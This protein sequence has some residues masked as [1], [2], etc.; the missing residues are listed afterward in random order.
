MGAS[1]TVASKLGEG[2]S[3]T[4][5]LPI[6]QVAPSPPPCE[7]M[8]LIATDVETK[9][10]YDEKYSPVLVIDPLYEA[11][12]GIASLLRGLGRRAITAA[13]LEEAEEIFKKGAEEQKSILMLDVT[14]KS[15][16]SAV[17]IHMLSYVG[18]TQ[19]NR[20]RCIEGIRKLFG[21][22]IQ[23]IVINTHRSPIFKI[24]EHCSLFNMFQMKEPVTSKELK[25]Q[26]KQASGPDNTTYRFQKNYIE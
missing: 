5:L 14:D 22:S 20:F 11:R 6:L 21:Y 24:I 16:I 25:S 9:D 2:S 8:S 12:V 3:F 18:M 26:L 13:S 1:L 19:T 17:I 23:V 4:V 15:E 10:Y 7:G